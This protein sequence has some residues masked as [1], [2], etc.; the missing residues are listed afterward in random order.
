MSKTL[1]AALAVAGMTVQTPPA[2]YTQQGVRAWVADENNQNGT[3]LVSAGVTDG[4]HAT[5]GPTGSGA[6]VEIAALDNRPVGAKSV[7]VTL[8]ASGNT[9]TS[10]LATILVAWG[11]TTAASL[12]RTAPLVYE[13]GSGSAFGVNGMLP[14]CE[15]PLSASGTFDVEFS[16]GGSADTS[17]VDVFLDIAG[18]TY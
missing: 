8:R 5:I 11:A 2:G 13:V 9:V 6:T 16:R 7:L 17:N 1:D 10:G 3:N 15:V 4:Q 18:Y 12:S 14:A